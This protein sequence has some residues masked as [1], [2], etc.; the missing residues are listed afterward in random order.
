[1]EIFKKNLKPILIILILLAIVAFFAF[2]YPEKSQAPITGKCGDGV[3]GLL[4]QK[5]PNLCPADCEQKAKKISAIPN[6]FIAIHNEPHNVPNG[7]AI[8]AHEYNTL[9]EMVK[10]ADE[11][12]IKLTLM[13]SAQWADYIS[14]SP[15]RMNDLEKWKKNGHE[16]AAH[17]HSIYHGNWDGYTDFPKETVI[18]ERLKKVKSPEQYLGT[19]DDF[20]AKLKKINPEINSGCVNDESDKAVFPDEIKYDTCSGFLNNGEL[21]KRMSDFDGN[22]EKAKNEYILTGSVNGIERKWLS[23]Y[24]INTKEN[25]E[26]AEVEFDSTNSGVFGAVIHSIPGEAQNF[27]DFL[28]F[29]HSKDPDGSESLTLTKAMESG[30]L[31]EKKLSSGKVNEKIV[32]GSK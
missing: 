29:I 20:M 12:N 27:Y 19:L 2:L 8:I 9:K 24:P 7:K 17:H 13:F 4:E 18:K 31:T 3:C 5:N 11:Y 10:K 6:Y 25:E 23:H 32:S 1:M 16:I 22:P 28:D 15:E 26:K 14:E 30:I 21:G